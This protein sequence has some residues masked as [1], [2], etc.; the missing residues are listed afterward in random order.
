MSYSYS[1]PS[2]VVI[3]L[4]LASLLTVPVAGQYGA[5]Q[6]ERKSPRGVGVLQISPT[7]VARLL[8]VVIYE[9]GKYYDATFYRSRPVPMS[10]VSDTLYEAQQAGMPAGTFTVRGAQRLGNAW[11]GVGAWKPTN[12]PADL[13]AKPNEAKAADAK[14]PHAKPALK[15]DGDPERPV[16][17]RPASASSAAPAPSP[18]PASG[19]P[20][21][22]DPDRPVLKRGGAPQVKPDSPEDAAKPIVVASRMVAVSDPEPATARPLE[23]MADDAEKAKLAAAMQELGLAELRRNAAA[24]RIAPPARSA[25]LT[26]VRVHFYDIDYSNNPQ[27]VLNGRYLPAGAARPLLVT[28]VARTDYNGQMT[29]VFFRL[30]DPSNLADRPELT[31]ID[32]VDLEGDGRAELLF[33]RRTDEGTGFVAYRLVGQSMSEVFATAARTS[34]AQ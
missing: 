8:P 26:D 7:G 18:S 5:R 11:V 21:P 17:R 14:T 19:T 25:K 12:A 4:L 1:N 10:L 2:R 34:R 15:D 31:F 28:L 20:A 22:E 9:G 29:R 32:V 30:G 23:Y 3:C 27:L 24:L 6:P 33:E 16:L 13:A